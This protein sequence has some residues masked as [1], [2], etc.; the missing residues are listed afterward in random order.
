MLA[1][2]ANFKSANAEKLHVILPWNDPDV[3]SLAVFFG[4]M[5]IGH[6]HYWGCNQFI[7]QRTLGAKSLAEGQKGI[8]LAAVIKRFLPLIVVITGIMAFPLFGAV[9]S[10][11]DKAYPT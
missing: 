9:I 11:P 8:M 2:L 5:W 3:P 7:T 4:G 1:G 6:L 10:T